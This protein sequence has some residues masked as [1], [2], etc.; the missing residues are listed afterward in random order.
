MANEVFKRNKRIKE[1]EYLY[2]EQKLLNK[3]AEELKKTNQAIITTPVLPETEGDS[4]D[5]RAGND[6]K[7]DERVFSEESEN[8]EENKKDENSIIPVPSV[9]KIVGDL[10]F[11]FLG[12]EIYP[13]R[14]GEYV[15]GYRIVEINSEAS[16]A[17]LE[18]FD[19]LH[20][21]GIAW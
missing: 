15:F 16:Y 19:K 4:Q 1:L 6:K 18:R 5:K 8:E 2:E 14:E 7:E 10:G 11:F 20:H 9:E 21:V 17:I 12:R 13:G 3:Q